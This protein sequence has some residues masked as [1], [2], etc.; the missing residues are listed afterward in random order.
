M[1]KQKFWFVVR[2]LIMLA[3]YGLASAWALVDRIL[4]GRKVPTW[5]DNE[6][7]GY[8]REVPMWRNSRKFWWAVYI[9]IICAILNMA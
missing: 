7:V 9:I 4:R 2:G 1:N 5:A 6:F 8:S 3:L